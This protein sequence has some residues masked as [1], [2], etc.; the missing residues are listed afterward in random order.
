MKKQIEIF[1]LYDISDYNEKTT[2]CTGT[3]EQCAE[4][5]RDWI[6]DHTI[7]EIEEMFQDLG[8]PSQFLTDPYAWY[9]ANG[10]V[11]VWNDWT[12]NHICSADARLT[13]NEY[14]Q[15]RNEVYS[16]LID[17]NLIGEGDKEFM[18]VDNILGS[19]LPVDWEK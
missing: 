13:P 3:L 1:E 7:A 8:N 5:L 11:E 19:V 16:G 9:D 6:D 10:N 12:L 14:H 2:L 17:N 4:A 15:I 18:A